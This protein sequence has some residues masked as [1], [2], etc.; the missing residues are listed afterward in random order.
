LS[1]NEIKINHERYKKLSN[2]VTNQVRK[3]TG[4]FNE[5]RIDKAGDEKEILKFVNVVTKP[6]EKNHLKL[7]E[8]EEVIE[9]EEEMATSLI[10]F[11][12]KKFHYLRMELIKSMSKNHFP[13]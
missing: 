2:R 8:G 3:D 4:Q 12:L 9:K 5:E 11:S 6:K 7:K 10:T 1:P 13:N